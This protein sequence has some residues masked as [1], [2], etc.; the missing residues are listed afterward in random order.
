[1]IFDGVYDYSQ[2][3]LITIHNYKWNEHCFPYSTMN[4]LIFFKQNAYFNSKIVL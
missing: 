2:K 1:M 3:D 4:N